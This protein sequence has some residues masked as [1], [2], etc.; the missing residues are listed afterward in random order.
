MLGTIRA[1][2][3]Q[4]ENKN[5]EPG[6]VFQMDRTVPLSLQLSSGGQHMR[7]SEPLTQHGNRLAI[8]S[9]EETQRWSPFGNQSRQTQPL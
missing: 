5:C 2:L 9:C 6:S 7:V 4:S 3:E 1:A 8:H